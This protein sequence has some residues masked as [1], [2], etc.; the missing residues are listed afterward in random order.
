MNKTL[1]YLFDP[2]CGWC[3]GATPIVSDLIEN[4]DISVE[5]LPTGLFSGEGSRPMTDDFAAFAWS[6]DQRISRLIGQ[7]FTERYKEMVLGD[8]HQFFD[9]GP[10][11]VTLT[12]VSLTNPQMEIN[13][14]KAVQRARYVDGLDVTALDILAPILQTCGL[15]EASTLLLSRSDELLRA[16]R[17]RVDRA[18][19]LMRDLGAN[20]VPT[21][22]GASG[23]KHSLLNTIDAYS[24]PQA[25]IKQ[26]QAI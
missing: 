7:S 16:N 24:T 8:F 25:L 22:I 10:A 6:N 11:T 12:A 19:N 4:Q 17:R 23:E 9:S 21:F 18:Q 26:L 3:Y 13:A 15:E 2:L 1:I 14:L 20:S 5:L